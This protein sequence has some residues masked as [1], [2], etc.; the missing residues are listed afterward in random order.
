MSFIPV[1][2]AVVMAVVFPLQDD[3]SLANGPYIFG[4]ATLIIL[5]W[6]LCRVCVSVYM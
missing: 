6:L 2:M 4:V 1:V 3:V 5:C